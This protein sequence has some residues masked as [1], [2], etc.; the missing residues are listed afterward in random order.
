MRNIAG[1]Y[2]DITGR[3][4]EFLH[5]YAKREFRMLPSDAKK[6]IF[7]ALKSSNLKQVLETW[8]TVVDQ[9]SID[10]AIEYVHDHTPY[11]FTDDTILTIATMDALLKSLKDGNEPDFATAYHTW[12]NKYPESGFGGQFRD[13]MKK[14][15]DQVL[16]YGSLGNGSAMRVGPIGY[17]GRE[18]IGVT[19]LAEE[20]ADCTHNSPEGIRGARAIAD[21]IYLMYRR[22]SDKQY[23]KRYVE[24]TYFYDLNR[25][26]KT[27]C[28]DYKFDATCPGSVPESIICFLESTDIESAIHLAISLGGDAD[29]MAMIA[30]SLAEAYYG[31]APD[32]MIEKVRE[33]LPEEM[34]SII[35]EF[36]E[37][38]G[39]K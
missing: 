18:L 11:K 8:R 16:P 35:S 28:K 17:V 4:F 37:A 23:L 27:I 3:T 12:A 14:P 1:I 29:T 22:R 36:N 32:Y 33:V 31:V 6:R 19:R 39:V 25:S 2:G 20:S 21:M 26:T 5:F 24:T 9:R 10:A 7:Q 30:G 34:F 15:L 13:W 38:F